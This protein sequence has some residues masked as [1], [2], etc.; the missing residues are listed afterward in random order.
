METIKVNENISLH[1]IDMK[2][3]KTNVVGVYIRRPLSNDEASKNAVL[4]YVLKNGCEKFPSSLRITK[5]LQSLYGATLNSG[6]LKNGDNQIIFFDAETISD[7]YAPE[8]E[9]LT[10]ELLD[11]L[12]NVIF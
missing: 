1:Y 6:V 8:N 10:N 3:L 2:K 11:L 7:K 5:H 4:S 9:K 12:L